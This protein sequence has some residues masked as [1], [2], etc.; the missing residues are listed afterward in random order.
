M[1][2][3]GDSNGTQAAP[4]PRCIPPPGIMGT[5]TERAVADR[6]GQELDSRCVGPRMSCGPR[7]QA[8]AESSGLRQIGWTGKRMRAASS[9]VA[10]E[11]TKPS[12]PAAASIPVWPMSS[13][14]SVEGLRVR[15]RRL[16]LSGSIRECLPSIWISQR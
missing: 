15:W 1:Q 2:D 11:A 13:R 9:A 7:A 12:S 4:R 3:G 6:S 16:S 10:V 8:V 5:A 14:T